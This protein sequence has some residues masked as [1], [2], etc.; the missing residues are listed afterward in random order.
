MDPTCGS[1]GRDTRLQKNGGILQY[2][3]KLDIFEGP[4]DLLLDLITKQKIDVCELSLTEIVQNYLDHI[5][6]KAQIDLEVTSEFLIIA[7]TLLK[8]KSN[9]LLGPDDNEEIHDLSPTEARELLITRLLEYKRFKNASA[10]LETLI[11]SQYGYHRRVEASTVPVFTAPELVGQTSLNDLASLLISVL[12]SS[13]HGDVLVSTQH[14]LC[15]PVNLGEKVDFVL[16]RVRSKGEE[17]FRNLTA[18]CLSRIEVAVTF[19]AV[20]ELRRTRRITVEQNEAFGEIVIRFDNLGQEQSG[21][22]SLHQQIA[23]DMHH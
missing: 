8:I 22:D 18:E 21:G 16:D 11:E 23:Q 12:T 2:Q 4:F 7:A 14:I 20:L 9:S 10:H 13:D 1:L 19:L 6:Q 3:V 5:G 17:T 15:P